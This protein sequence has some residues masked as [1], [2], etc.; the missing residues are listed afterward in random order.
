M[1]QHRHRS[2]GFA[3]APEYCTEAVKDTVTLAD[4]SLTASPA[5]QGLQTD[6]RRASAMS[7]EKIEILPKNCE[8][9]VSPCPI[10]G[11]ECGENSSLCDVAISKTQYI[12]DVSRFYGVD[13]LYVV[14]SGE[15]GF[16]ASLPDC[17]IYSQM[18]I[19]LCG[20]TAPPQGFSPPF[21][22]ADLATPL[23]LPQQGAAR[24]KPLSIRA[25]IARGLEPSG[26]VAFT[27]PCL[28]SWGRS[29]AMF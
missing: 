19:F 13:I 5:V 18:S 8:I 1:Q 20:P 3:V 22:A 21:P 15:I 17:L 2:T 14:V 4:V 25:G 11:L 12:V 27:A 26:A 10:D 6:I 23:P 24:A 7:L 16:G 28:V 29:C 9:R